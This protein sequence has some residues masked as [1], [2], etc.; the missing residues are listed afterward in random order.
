MQEQ[1]RFGKNQ[2]HFA[3]L[4]SNR[5]TLGISVHPDTSVEVKAPKDSDL[6]LIRDKVRKRASWIVKQKRYFER[7]LP[8]VPSK[9]YVSGET[10]RYLGK[11]YRLKV[12][13]SEKEQVLLKGGFLEVYTQEKSNRRKVKSLLDNWYR[14]RA[15]TQFEQR[16]K[17]LLEESLRIKAKYPKI[18]LKVMAKRWGSCT[19]GGTIFV[20][21]ELIKAP[22]TCI[23]Y[24]L[25]HELC[26]LVE[27][28]HSPKFY[29]LLDRAMP[30][31]KKRKEKLEM[32]EI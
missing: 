20:N 2:I 19:K 14:E 7:F 31:W 27:H 21:P 24:V 12:Y 1:I 30:D 29:R 28:N 11:Q 9:N 6:D 32:V 13:Q 8:D 22:S 5:K 25:M 16:I 17:K 10:F 3:L 4:Y 26:H 15:L 23:D 18:K